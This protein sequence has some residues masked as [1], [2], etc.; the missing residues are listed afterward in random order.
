MILFFKGL[1]NKKTIKRTVSLMLA[2]IMCF[3][4]NFMWKEKGKKRTYYDY[5]MARIW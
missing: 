5:I 3:F 4:F 1:I 2:F